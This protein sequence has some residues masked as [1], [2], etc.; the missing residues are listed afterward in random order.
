MFYL[1]IIKLNL[2]IRAIIVNVRTVSEIETNFCRWLHVWKMI[3]IKR[4][5]IRRAATEITNFF[6]FEKTEKKIKPTP[7]KNRRRDNNRRKNNRYTSRNGG[8][9]N[10]IS[11]K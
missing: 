4:K 6:S 10:A 3:F 2:K 8:V 1:F 11:S 9:P 5:K 7:Q